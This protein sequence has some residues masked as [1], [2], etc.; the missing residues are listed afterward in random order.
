[1]PPVSRPF[2]LTVSY[3]YGQRDES[4]R[5]LLHLAECKCF[6]GAESYARL[7]EILNAMDGC[8]ERALGDE[9][10]KWDL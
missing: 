8:L 2:R 3:M 4:G 10:G 9:G 1:M 6:T 7:A 5:Q